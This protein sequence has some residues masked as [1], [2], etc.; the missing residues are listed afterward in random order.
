MV[1]KLIVKTEFAFVVID[2]VCYDSS[3][4]IYKIKK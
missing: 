3:Y 1:N 4:P 2:L